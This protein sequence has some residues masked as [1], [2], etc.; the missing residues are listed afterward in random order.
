MAKPRVKPVD[1]ADIDPKKDKPVMLQY[2]I[3]LRN[4]NTKKI[5]ASDISIP[6]SLMMNSPTTA[7]SILIDQFKKIADTA[8][9]VRH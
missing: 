6:L 2:E 4:K 7:Q 8:I 9:P 1:M 3:L 5:Y